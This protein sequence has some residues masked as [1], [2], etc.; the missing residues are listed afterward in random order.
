MR[1]VVL[2]MLALLATASLSGCTAVKPWER[3]LLARPDM[4]WEPDPLESARHGHVYF[5]AQCK[6]TGWH[7]YPAGFRIL[8]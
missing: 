3:D 5:P 4:A 6:I 8:L 7:L 2:L 1:I